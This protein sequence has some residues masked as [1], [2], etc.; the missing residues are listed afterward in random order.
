MSQIVESELKSSQ[1]FGD[2]V[3]L[4]V[5]DGS[6]KAGRV[7]FANSD[8]DCIRYYL[9]CLKR[10]FDLNPEKLGFYLQIREDYDFES[11]SRWWEEK[12]K[13]S[14]DKISKNIGRNTRVEHGIMVIGFNNKEI[15]DL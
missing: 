8:S 11:I 1:D 9:S 7:S 10:M 5:G 14:R 2:I 13:I 4:I 3:G 12:I 6:I 15:A